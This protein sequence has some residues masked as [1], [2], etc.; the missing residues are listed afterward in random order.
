MRQFYLFCS[1]ESVAGKQAFGS[2][3][4]TPKKSGNFSEK[5]F[6][7]VIAVAALAIIS[8]FNIAHSE[9]MAPPT[10]LDFDERSSVNDAIDDNTFPGQFVGRIIPTGGDASIT[11]SL[12]AGA[13]DTDNAR[14]T[15]S[16][17]SL[18]AAQ[19]I[20]FETHPDP[21]NLS[22]RVRAA[23]AGGTGFE[24]ILPLSIRNV[25]EGT[26]ASFGSQGDEF[27]VNEFRPSPQQ[28]AAIAR[29]A[30][31][32]F[33]VVWQNQNDGIFAQRY[34]A[35]ADPVGEVLRVDDPKNRNQKWADV[36]MAD[37]GD[38]VVVWQGNGNTGGSGTDII[39]RLYTANG[40]PGNEFIVNTITVDEQ[41]S[42]RVAMNATGGFI[43]AWQGNGDDGN[44]ANGIEDASGIFFRRFQA[45]GTA[46]DVNQVQANTTTA[47]A[48]YQPAVGLA[49]DG[50]FA[51][52]W[53]SGGN[54]IYR[55]YNATLAGSAEATAN[56][57]T[58]G[59]QGLSDLSMR[60]NGAYMITW[61]GEQ[62]ADN[63]GIYA[64]RFNN[65]GNPTAAA[66]EFTVSAPSDGQ[67][68]PH[69]SM[70]DNGTFVITFTGPGSGNEVLVR[71]YNADQSPIGGA[72]EVN[73]LRL[74]TQRFSDVA[75]GEDGSFVVAWEG[76]NAG[77]SIG[78]YD[79]YAQRFY[80]NSA[81]TAVALNN[82]SIANG[83]M[84]DTP[85]GNFTTTDPNTGD[86][87]SYALVSGTGDTDNDA[88]AIQRGQL[89]T[90]A[91]VQATLPANFSIRVRSTDALGLF[92][93]SAFTIEVSETQIPAIATNA[94]LTLDQGDTATIAQSVLEVT[95]AESGPGAITF[96][97]TQV[98]V[99][100]VL[101][102]S[103]T[104]LGVDQTF[105]QADINNGII[106]YIHNGSRNLSDSLKFTASDGVGGAIAETN[107]A[108]SVT[109]IP[110]TAP[111]VT[112]NVGIDVLQG[113]TATVAQTVLEVTDAESTPAA[114][115]YTLVSTPVNGSL[116]RSN[117]ALAANET[118]TQADIND[119]VI[120]YVH[121]GGASTSDSFSFTASD[122]DGSTIEETQVAIT[123]TTLNA[124]VANAGADQVVTDENGDGLEE[125][126][127][128]G[129]ASSD[130]DGTIES[131]VWIK[132]D[133]DTVATG[134]N[135]T[136]MLEVEVHTIA[137][138]VTD[139]GGLTAS[140]TVVIT[141][142]APGSENTMPVVA[143]N[144]GL[145]LP[146][147]GSQATITAQELQVTDAESEPEAITYTLVAKPTSGSLLKN[148]TP[149][150]DGGTFTQKDI[151]DGLIAY[152]HD[153]SA[154][155]TDV[156][157]FSVADG[158]GGTIAD[159]QFAIS[160]NIVTGLGDEINGDI[161][162]TYPNPSQES[163]FIKMSNQTQG[164]VNIRISN[165]IGQALKSVN[166]S[167]RMLENYPIDISN[168]SKGTYFVQI[169][170][171]Q[172]TVIK[173]LI[174]E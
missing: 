70:A 150:D 42:A 143:V 154:N 84:V 162:V 17:D 95:D 54:I 152:L 121:D 1:Q 171:D 11:Y 87:F 32:N 174:K 55:F 45:N 155:A 7:K 123:I 31:N 23:D 35:T 10:N 134:A 58:T 142:N 149:M 72:F 83:S 146:Q 26:T 105:T 44:V 165:T 27:K 130:A 112:T 30:N 66:A 71:R 153:N 13:G 168:L 94:G 52:S 63:I 85:V 111:E 14:F 3:V 97:L 169:E 34:D 62:T 136:V 47:G 151:D 76:D 29:D 33:V 53:T 114:I 88:F 6:T 125:I 2:R 124:P 109:E 82:T 107:F 59:S 164:D 16:S 86:R 102:K 25:D 117:T 73:K 158:N 167:S 21:A 75:L 67:F 122:E 48:Q 28:R 78:D 126:T 43:V 93:E 166:L 172:Q 4:I 19:F 116:Q 148:D 159:T 37:N 81:P 170:A 163:L 80:V 99:Q 65:D 77:P 144:A 12:V 5:T 50:K 104:T 56:N 145:S 74:G 24:Q 49:D 128:D 90:A 96:T 108:I 60:G 106:T 92:V 68:A 98:P 22:I 129:S 119:E 79:I 160:I 131:Y 118:F 100:G 140:D 36:A 137:L 51:L 20:D 57:E 18:F 127:L 115:I 113:D 141:V 161:V 15:I 38:F 139:N 46:I 110:N 101:Q 120:T 61:Q 156:F 9:V 41:D 39:A 173:N 40:T 147:Q 135:P 103:A 91:P 138:V 8:T 64:R 69:V 133:T 132:N 89:V 157:T